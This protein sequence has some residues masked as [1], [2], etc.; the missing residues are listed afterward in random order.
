MTYLILNPMA[1]TPEYF[2]DGAY[3]TSTW[4]TDAAGAKVFA[5]E[6]SAQKALDKLNGGKRHKIIAAE[7]LKTGDP[8]WLRVLPHSNEARRIAK[9]ETDD[10]WLCKGEILFIG[11]KYITV[12]LEDSVCTLKFEIETFNEAGDQSASY[13]LFATRHEAYSAVRGERL[14]MEIRNAVASRTYNPYN[15]EPLNLADIETM[16]KI[17]GV[18]LS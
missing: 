9:L 10:A 8:V 2:V 16:A 7:P 11:Q 17:L 13:K 1:P 3:L 4:T 6:Y 15:K 18:P 14:W 12:Q 5:D